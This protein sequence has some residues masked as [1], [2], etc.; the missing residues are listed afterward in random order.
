MTDLDIIKECRQTGKTRT[1]TKKLLEKAYYEQMTNEIDI[2]TVGQHAKVL[3]EGDTV[4]IMGVKYQKV[5][6]EPEELKTLYDALQCPLHIN[7]YHFNEDQKDWICDIVEK[8][9]PDELSCDNGVHNGVY[10]LGWNDAIETIKD[11]LK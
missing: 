5:E 10:E 11:K 4:T 3:I 1:T 2:S 6:E 8:W 7:G 9:L